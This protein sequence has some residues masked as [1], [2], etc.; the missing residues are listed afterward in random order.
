MTLVLKL[1]QVEGGL[2][3]R[4]SGSVGLELAFLTS[5]PAEADTAS[6]GTYP[7]RATALEYLIFIWHTQ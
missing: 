3:K 7:L 2:L 6:P 4:V 5:A 1:G